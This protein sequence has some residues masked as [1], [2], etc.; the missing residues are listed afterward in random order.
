MATW[1]DDTINL[2]SKL[3]F[4]MSILGYEIVVYVKGELW[5]RIRTTASYNSI[6]CGERAS[7]RID[8][9]EMEDIHFFIERRGENNMLMDFKCLQR[10]PIKVKGKVRT[11]GVLTAISEIECGSSRL[12]LRA[13]TSPSEV[14]GLANDV[15]YDKHFRVLDYK[16]VIKSYDDYYRDKWI[17]DDEEFD[18]NG[19]AIDGDSAED[20]YPS[21]P[22][23]RICTPE[24][25]LEMTETTSLVQAC[26]TKI[27][28]LSLQG[29]NLDLSD[30]S[31]STLKNCN[32]RG[33]S[34]R[35]ASLD[36]TT[37][38]GCDLM[39]CDFSGASM[40]KTVF[41]S[42]KLVG[43]RFRQAI[44]E[45]SNLSRA[46][47]TGVDFCDVDLSY[48]N[49]GS[50]SFKNAKLDGA[51]LYKTEAAYADF[52]GSAS[53]TSSAAFCVF[54][55]PPDS[56]HKIQVDGVD[57]SVTHAGRQHRARICDLTLANQVLT[58]RGP[59]IRG[60]VML[61][62]VLGQTVGKRL[63]LSGCTLKGL[64]LR[65]FCMH[66]VD[67]R[68]AVLEDVDLRDSE[69]GLVDLRGAI[70][71]RVRMNRA[72]L[73]KVDARG[74]DFR[75]VEVQGQRY[76]RGCVFNGRFGGADL[77][78]LNLQNSSINQANFKGANLASVDFSWSRFED[79]VLESANLA[80]AAL[81]G[82]YFQK[83]L[84]RNARFEDTDLSWS[85]FQR[86]SV[87]PEMAVKLFAGATLIELE[88]F[89]KGNSSV[90]EVYQSEP[91]FMDE[92]DRI[93]PGWESGTEWED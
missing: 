56:V 26:D 54:T 10:I 85:N 70:L 83:T 1:I 25:F 19:V 68:N 57:S 51:Y 53:S 14:E 38:E 7:I 74:V 48:A 93:A 58:S 27:E 59:I 45:G 15:E 6:G 88:Y 81:K 35:H 28:G 42:S 23:Q 80:G 69:L 79:V 22:A 46:N 44:M 75:N 61:R 86:T 21:E 20:E 50:A 34:F 90:E 40:K 84:F 5:D 62:D 92:L 73:L 17:Q 12:E 77:R 29:G 71:T 72:R 66:H 36:R 89:P 43:S 37:F 63:N 47:L 91:N 9:D 78:G 31:D 33:T 16:Q 2:C 52:R 65:G 30:L 18:E 11:R 64:N 82:C 39:D 24:M 87:T 32:L 8:D 41:S 3:G 4:D 76:S 13:Y 67:L 49:L 60:L 55:E